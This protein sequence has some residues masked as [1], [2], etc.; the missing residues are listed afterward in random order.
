[1][2]P[3]VDLRGS[4]VAG[5]LRPHRSFDLVWVIEDVKKACDT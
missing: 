5:R 1:M 4:G 3:V 2:Y